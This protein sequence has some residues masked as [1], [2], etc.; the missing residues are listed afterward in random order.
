MIN[1][2]K[3][4]TMTALAAAFCFSATAQDS[5]TT[6]SGESA[7]TAAPKSY[8]AAEAKAEVMKALREKRIAASDIGVLYELINNGKIPEAIKKINSAGSPAASG[9]SASTGNDWPNFLGANGNGSSPEKGLLRK[10]PEKGPKELW[11]APIGI[12][13]SCPSIAGSDA[14]VIM[15]NF[16]KPSDKP[17]EGKYEK[18][19]C[20]D[21][22][23]GKKR[24]EYSYKQDNYYCNWPQGGPRA[25][26]TITD[27][28]VFA[29]GMMGVL[30]CLDR[31][32]GS[33]VWQADLTK[34]T[35]PVA[36]LTKMDLKAFSASPVVIDGIIVLPAYKSD[37]T[38]MLI[39]IN[40]ATGKTAWT[41]QDDAKQDDA[42]SKKSPKD[43][44]SV[45]AITVN[46]KKLATTYMNSCLVGLNPADGKAVWKSEPINGKYKTGLGVP[47]QNEGKLFYPAS[48]GAACQVEASTG[49]VLWKN[50]IG[51]I[52]GQAVKQNNA[53]FAIGVT[54]YSDVFSKYQ[55]WVECIDEN[56]GAVLWKGD[57]FTVGCSIMGADG[58]L[59]VRGF[60]SLM[61]VD[62]SK[63][64]YTVLG[65]MDDMFEADGKFFDG[66]SIIGFV[67]PVLAN[68]KLY[69]RLPSELLCLDVKNN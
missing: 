21:A 18:I 6:P 36:D 68:G 7:E 4:F 31:K 49:K 44:G 13:W 42:K 19:V 27:K 14:V 51:I 56:S 35:C 67:M 38:P 9:T 55:G 65:K 57:R 23:T 33:M 52:W 60:K 59:F 20:F 61:L 62:A 41:W 17:A 3:V 34:D 63:S 64:G 66:P 28:N 22:N 25:T 16:V 8:T 45:S 11:R 12:G 15:A 37:K 29:I 50:N 26:P 10:W 69:V 1:A 5:Q 40:G 32:N 54:D 53:Y 24:W 58:L 30:T 47:V 46:G 43:A 2:Y 48:F 39:G